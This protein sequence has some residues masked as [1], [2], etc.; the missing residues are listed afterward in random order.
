[1]DTILL[2]IL[3]NVIL[4]FIDDA[5]VSL[6]G[7]TASQ[8]STIDVYEASKAIDGNTDGYIAHGSCSRTRKS[9]MPEIRSVYIM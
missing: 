6:S 1:M 8:S 2:P 5:I 7:K 3:T 4:F 9:N